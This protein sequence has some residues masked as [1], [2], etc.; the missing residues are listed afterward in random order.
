MTLGRKPGDR[1]AHAELLVVRMRA[2][3]Q[4]VHG[5]EGSGSSRPPTWWERD[6]PG[7][8]TAGALLPVAAREA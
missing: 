2:D 1:A 7:T 3:N 4:D 8:V 5:E 6:A